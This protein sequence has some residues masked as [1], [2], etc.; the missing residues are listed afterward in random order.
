MICSL[1]GCLY[2]VF[3]MARIGQAQAFASPK[4]SHRSPPTASS[5]CHSL[6][7]PFPPA[8]PPM[9][10]VDAC[11]FPILN[12]HPQTLLPPSSFC[13]GASAPVL[14]VVRHHRLQSAGVHVRC[15]PARPL[16]ASEQA[17]GAGAAVTP[18]PKGVRIR[19][20]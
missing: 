9:F 5:H 12:T 3:P 18:S 6:L 10:F 8:A 16:P 1:W 11:F 20:P 4:P 15:G 2:S 17:A 14:V 19:T 7:L 13:W